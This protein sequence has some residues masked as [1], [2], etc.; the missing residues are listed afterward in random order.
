MIVCHELD[1][2]LSTYIQY[3]LIDF[4]DAAYMETARFNMSA[5]IYRIRQKIYYFEYFCTVNFNSTTSSDGSSHYIRI[6]S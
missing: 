4:Q 2:D 1:N 3:R 6:H 5:W